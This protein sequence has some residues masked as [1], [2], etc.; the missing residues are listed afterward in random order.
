[1]LFNSIAIKL[2]IPILL[3]ILCIDGIL[4]T[5]TTISRRD[6]LISSVNDHIL[7]IARDHSGAVE[8]EFEKTLNITKTLADSFAA[9]KELESA[10]GLGRESVKVILNK[11]LQS[12]PSFLAV[13]TLWEPDAFDSMDEA[14]RGIAAHDE[15]GRFIPCWTRDSQGNIV[16][17]HARDYK[18]EAK[19]GYYTIPRNTKKET[20]IDP[21]LY[22]LGGKQILMVSLVS[23]VIFDNSFYGVVGVDLSLDW[24]QNIID[25][26]FIHEKNAKFNI[27]SNNGILAAVSGE[28][29]LAGKRFESVYPH[30][31]DEF[32]SNNNSKQRIGF[33]DG[34]LVVFTPIY[35]GNTQ[36]PWSLNII[37]PSDSITATAFSGM[38]TEIVISIILTLISVVFIAFFINLKMKPLRRIAESAEKVASGRLVYDAIVTE[39]DEIG[40]VNASFK[41]MVFSL[42]EITSACQALAVGDFSQPVQL[43]SKDDILGQTVNFMVEN[44]KKIVKQLNNIA[45]GGFSSKFR[46]FSEKDQLG[47]AIAELISSLRKMTEENERQ[48]IIKTGTMELHT[49]MRGEKEISTLSDN[50]ITFLCRYMNAPIGAFYVM[51]EEGFLIL[52]GSFAYG[53]Q[54][55]HSSRFAP[56]EG[57]TGQASIEKQIIVVTDVPED[58]VRIQ[59]GVGNAAPRNILL[60]PL[61]FENAVKGV[62]EIGAFQEFSDVHLSFLSQISDSIA[63]AINS[64]QIRNR[65]KTLLGH[66]QEQAD[67]LKSQ[68]EALR[69]SNLDLEKQ[70][71]ALKQSES[72]LKEQQEE[73]RHTNEELQEQAQLL[74]EQKEDIQKK[75]LELEMAGKL[76]KEKVDD[77]ERTSK[78]KSEFLANMSHELRT[79]LNSILLLSR[80]IADNKDGNLT[81]K[82]VEFA[83]TIHASGSDL[84][85]LIN[86]VLD[87]SKVESGKMEL[88]P[89]EIHLKDI[90]STIKRDFQHLSQK[91]EIDFV[92][93]ISEDLPVSIFTDRQRTEQ[94]IKNFLSNAFKFTSC[95]KITFNVSRPSVNS[96][97][98]TDLT[99]SNSIAFSVTDTGIGIPRDKQQTVFEAFKQADGTTSRKYGGTGLGLSISVEL[100]KYLGGEIQLESEEGKGS[101]FTLILPEKLEQPFMAEKKK[102]QSSLKNNEDDTVNNLTE[103]EKSPACIEALKDDRRNLNH[104][105]RVILIV[106]DDIHF[107][108]ILSNISRSR[109]FKILLADNGQTGLHFADYYKPDAIILDF[110]LPQMDGLSVLARLKDNKKTGHIP[111]FF[112]SAL[113]R[114]SHALQ[115]GA[116][117]YAVK[118][119]SLDDL[120]KIY[121]KI[122][123]IIS[124]SVKPIPVSE[125][126]GEVMT[127]DHSSPDRAKNTDM[128]ILGKDDVL[129][130]KK[131]LLVDDD[132]RNVYAT[133]NIL[134]EKGMKVIVGK[135]GKEGIER[136]NKEKAI[137]LVLM[138]IMMP[139]MDGYEAMKEIRK[140]NRFAKLPIIA[141]TAKAMKGDRALC[142]EAGA[143]DYLAKPF[144][145]EKLLSMLRVWLY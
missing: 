17:E 47:T 95:G 84:L 89:E 19:G 54:T 46:P 38:W 96:F 142:I 58:Y 59:S 104:G 42:K 4:I 127:E 21:Y 78:Y 65:M 22:T 85:N 77:L 143:D 113:D 93:E 37:I 57:L 60:C 24:I 80:L 34:N 114:A 30:L 141:L 72:M 108:K 26:V 133:T 136:L 10:S 62:I 6:H 129:N 97:S 50:I 16:L 99:R 82:Q 41:N 124:E 83:D 64:A 74:E 106:E 109:E 87:L 121:D 94:I 32:S 122:N 43:R 35:I 15:T 135:N 66:T 75:H 128:M 139:I 23:P 138:D 76:I 61:V 115:M 44:I 140:D 145:T 118:P 67:M 1:M 132:M 110:D 49:L 86:E 101:T 31:K 88:N 45:K 25:N 48:N 39:D 9:V 144:D 14:F 131:V 69:Q 107:A 71:D 63:I 28:P 98:Q 55:N 18:N 111:V 130:N 81:K 117:G 40:K 91:K 119:V 13:Y 103:T 3:L 90:A 29:S 68:Q 51:D 120:E 7:A 53:Q 100:A 20:V 2:T 27:I 73:L 123:L 134:E 8:A 70:A 102:R 36:T 52:T 112:V 137:D 12:N 56:G 92:I 79:P 11:T 125:S 5:Y 116:A 105:D 33:T 126:P